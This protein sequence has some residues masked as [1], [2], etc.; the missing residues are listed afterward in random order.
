MRPPIA[1][2]VLLCLTLLGACHEEPT[3]AEPSG[4]ATFTTDSGQVRTSPL[5]VA[6]TKDE[7]ERG[8]MGRTELAGDSGMVFDFGGETASSFWMKDTL[9]PLSIAFWGEDARIV[10]ILEMEPC[11]ADPCTLYT[12]RSPYTMALEMNAG[13]FDEHGVRIGDRVELR[14]ATE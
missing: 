5:E 3:P 1:L 4:R 8:L 2:L 7:R 11:A 9:I 6:D 12:P 14:A 13:W 10:D